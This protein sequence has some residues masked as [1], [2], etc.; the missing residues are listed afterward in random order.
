MKHCI[1]ALAATALGAPAYAQDPADVR[2]IEVEIYQDMDGPFD[3]AEY[4]NE[5]T[6]GAGALGVVSD[7]L[8][9]GT[10][11]SIGWN[12]RYGWHPIN[13]LTWELAYT[14]ATDEM[15]VE[16]EADGTVATF[17]ETTGK[18]D[19]IPMSPV[20]PFIAAGVGY[21]AF[22]AAQQDLGTL[23][24]PVAAGLEGRADNLMLATRLTWRPTFF[25]AVGL[26]DIGGDSWMWT[27]DIGTR[28]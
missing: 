18:M 27:A 9:P 11:S 26:S 22:T 2:V 21:G 13:L 6:I 28:F 17:L 7:G 12:L 8:D 23:T 15:T 16:D 19:L 10:P 5:F 4:Q 24:V 20:S 1:T 3:P 14:G 25:D